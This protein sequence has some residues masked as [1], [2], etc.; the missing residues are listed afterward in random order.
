VAGFR[1]RCHLEKDRGPPG[2]R[3]RRSLCSVSKG[4]PGHVAPARTPHLTQRSRDFRFCPFEGGHRY[5]NDLRR[6][7]RGSRDVRLLQGRAQARNTDAKRSNQAAPR[8]KAVQHRQRRGGK[9]WNDIPAPLALRPPMRQRISLSLAEAAKTTGLS[10][11]TILAA[12]EDGRIT[13][14]KDMLDAWY[15]ERAPCRRSGRLASSPAIEWRV[16][17][18]VVARLPARRPEGD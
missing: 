2:Q 18:G 9:F 1:P 14:M 4:P 15:V 6:Q 17:L 5:E 12:I 13:G 11:S 16:H 8:P 10:E 3:F 7:S